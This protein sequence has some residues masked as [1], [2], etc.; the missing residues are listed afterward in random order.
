MSMLLLEQAVA[1]AGLATLMALVALLVARWCRNARIDAILCIGI[2]IKLVTPSVFPV[3]IVM[4]QTRQAVVVPQAELPTAETLVQEPP[5]LE[6]QA[7]TAA[8]PV[9]PNVAPASV[10]A[11]VQSP[12]VSPTAQP[13]ITSLLPSLLWFWKVKSLLFVWIAG[14]IVSLILIVGRAR[15]FQRCLRLLPTNESFGALQQ[16][17]EQYAG[18]MVRGQRPQ[19][20]ILDG[21]F[22][23][24]TWNWSGR[25]TILLPRDLLEKLTLEQQTMVI[26]HELAHV[27]R[28]DHLIR[29]IE[30]LVQ[31]VYWWFP[32]V[33]W[34]RHRLHVAQEFCCDAEVSRRFPD[35]QD[36]YSE[37]LFVT[38][39]WLLQ[40]KRAP[41]LAVEFGQN[42]TLKTRIQNLLQPTVSDRLSI[43]GRACCVVGIAILL[44]VSIQF[45]KAENPTKQPVANGE[46]KQFTI[47]VR[48]TDYKGQPISTG[49]VEVTG[50]APRDEYFQQ[51]ASI[52]NGV[53]SVSLKNRN[54]ENIRFK[55]ES[56]IYMTHYKQLTRSEKD[57]LMTLDQKYDF[58]LRQGI[59]IGGKIID[60]AG[61]PVTG[62]RIYSYT[63]TNQSDKDG[64]DVFDRRTTTNERGEW[65]LQGADP[66][67]TSLVV[68][69]AESHEP[70]A[71]KSLPVLQTQFDALKNR[72]DVRTIETAAKS[73]GLVVD[74]TGKPV[75]GA[76]ILIKDVEHYREFAENRIPT[77]NEK[78]EFPLAGVD[79]ASWSFI[80]FSPDW[81]LQAARVKFP[82]TE[83]VK[84]VM[85]KGKQVAF[86]TVNE[87][88]QPVSGIHF[89]PGLSRANLNTSDLSL[90]RVLDFLAHRKLIPNESDANG[91]VVW[92]NAPDEVLGYQITSKE[93]LSQP[94]GEYGP[95]ETPHVL[96]FRPTI[97]LVLDII[98]DSTGKSI[99]DYQVF[100]GTHFKTNRPGSW[101]WSLVRP[102]KDLKPGR[103]ETKLRTLDRLVQYRVQ[104][105]GYQLATTV[106]FDAKELPN[107]PI[108][109][110]IRL[111]KLTALAVTVRLKDGLPAAG[112]KIS[113]KVK[114][115]ED[116][117]GL[118]VVAGTVDP[119][120]A[121]SE[122]IA[123]ES[124]QFQLELLN[125]PFLCF[126]SH[127]AG[128]AE[129]TDAE[130]SQSSDIT[131]TP[132]STVEGRLQI[133][134]QPVKDL[135]VSLQG[136][137]VF[138]DGSS[139]YPNVSKQYSVKTD[140]DGR[141][142]MERVPAGLW[143][144]IITYD[145]TRIAHNLA[146]SRRIKVE[147]PAGQTVN[148]S[149][150]DFPVSVTG[151]L[152]FPADF[153]IDR[154]RSSISLVKRDE[155]AEGAP[156]ASRIGFPRDVHR[157]AIPEDGRFELHQLE[158]GTY[159]LTIYMSGAERTKEQWAF[160]CPQ[161]TPDMFPAKSA[162]PVIDLGDILVSKQSN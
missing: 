65:S 31:S 159:D 86:K 137:H 92:N 109:I 42:K 28:F 13:V 126:I 161:I 40:H 4:E 125:E 20:R 136:E 52:K 41:A 49:S 129:L 147:L 69:L 10:P 88:G 53:A 117:S 95:S 105:K 9:K 118:K 112:A 15:Q 100:Q 154:S 162:R 30:T 146:Y 54:V 75:S 45:V 128:Y 97:P 56:P 145:P 11:A 6:P 2:L 83:P 78:G 132:W 140:S 81:A 3:P 91:N 148:Q 79:G 74:E 43:A 122:I 138:Y 66:N 111:K 114:R 57:P 133:K 48:V 27:R 62:A 25:T 152:V 143:S 67:F 55:V 64:M 71:G 116:I 155:P 121:T 119:A 134:Q 142:R 139:I 18:V 19:L 47:E 135:T 37:A 38:A 35:Q 127:D 99:E 84:I 150:D 149:L 8:S 16:R 7:V 113:L 160:K 73:I 87:A 156:E 106:T 33:P 34:V 130:L 5:Q 60:K 96:V 23:P 36:E 70:D 120:S 76:M 26:V 14:S 39:N 90:H 46:V 101:D 61:N 59:A 110:T 102:A 107:D 144:Q 29:W 12:A 80:V 124:G 63:P 157:M 89:Y 77:T 123:D 21:L 94:G 115:E 82:I 103:Y 50:R 108:S 153:K 72:T 17:F 68:H 1:N 151:R 158:P 22:S 93:M 24:L 141:Y 44:A 51:K 104:A 32:L 85:H 131:L 98:D 58:R